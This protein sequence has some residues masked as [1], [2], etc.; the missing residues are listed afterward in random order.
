VKEDIIFVKNVAN[1]MAQY[2]LNMKE[3]GINNVKNK[4]GGINER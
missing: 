1:I 2:F 3:W 4:R